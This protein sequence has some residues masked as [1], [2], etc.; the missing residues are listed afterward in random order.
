MQN[1]NFPKFI[2]GTAWKEGATATLVEEAVVTGFTAIDTANQPR[3]YSEPLVGEALLKLK[4][5]GI[6]RERLF[7]QTKFTSPNGQ[8]HRIPYDPRADIATQVATS[9]QSSLNHLHTDYVDSYLLHG[10]YSRD[11][12]IEEDWQVWQAMEKLYVVGKTKY[13]GVSNV[14]IVQL[15][16]LVQEA[17]I[18]PMIVQNRCYARLGWDKSVREFCRL[19]QIQYQGFSLLTA[20]RE[21]WGHDRVAKIAQRLNKTPAQ[22]IFR[23]ATLIGITPLTGTTDEKHMQQDLQIFDFNLSAEEVVEIE[24]I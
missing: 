15:K 20:N 10:P 19:H 13:I 12:L 22:I 9:F 16:L 1:G 14:N 2:Y 4:E 21:V 24:R 3:H 18:K 7:L 5:Q 11:G 23:F 8:D 17:K 6:A